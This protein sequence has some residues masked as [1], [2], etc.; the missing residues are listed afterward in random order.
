MLFRSAQ[1]NVGCV[2]GC[3]HRGL[4]TGV[5]REEWG[6]DGAVVSD[7]SV[8]GATE[9]D[10]ILRAGCDM[11]LAGFIG[12]ASDYDTATARSV[13]RESLH[14]ICYAVANSNAM[15][16]IAPGAKV[17]Q[18]ISGWKAGVTA[19]TVAIVG[20]L[21][22]GW[23]SYAR[24]RKNDPDTSF[25]DKKAQKAAKKQEKRDKKAAKKQAKHDK[26]AQK[27]GEQAGE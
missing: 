3:A 2:T 11:W 6:F 16:G 21:A 14:R 5:L 4:L 25:E 20:A 15:N 22:I 27:K 1:S 7:L 17:S 9:H 12:S 24:K 18:G 23:A 26:K 19:G 10:L 13:M 8:A